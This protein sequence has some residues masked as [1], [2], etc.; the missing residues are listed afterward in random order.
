MSAFV[1]CF[2]REGACE[3]LRL[4]LKDA[5]EKA[6]VHGFTV[7]DGNSRQ[8]CAAAS[9]TWEAPGV[10][11]IVEDHDAERLAGEAARA[12]GREF[13]RDTQTA[14]W[15]QPFDYSAPT[16]GAVYVLW[17]LPEPKNL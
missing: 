11:G 2:A 4:S 6:G 10:V 14:F 7:T 16:P 17:T 9:L 12:L 5:L 1:F 3:E 13:Y 15:T 8:G